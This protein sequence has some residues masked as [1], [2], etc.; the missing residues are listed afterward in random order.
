LVYRGLSGDRGYLS[1]WKA[2]LLAKVDRFTTVS[3]VISVRSIWQWAVASNEHAV[4]NARVAATE[5]S[6]RRLE[7]AEVEQFLVTY[8]AAATSTLEQPVR[9]SA[10]GS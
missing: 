4:A 8:A 10:A 5:C 6:R 1:G 7:R 9:A 2:P 3:F